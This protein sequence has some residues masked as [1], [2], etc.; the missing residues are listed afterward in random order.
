MPK[1]MDCSYFTQARTIL[2]ALMLGVLI[3][4]CGDSTSDSKP[5]DKNGVSDSGVVVSPND[6]RQY[7]TLTLDNGI[8]VLLVSDPAVEK[9]AAALSVGVGLL[10][11]PMAYQGMAHYLEHML[12]L[13]TEKYP[14]S[15]GYMAFIQENGGANNAY[16]WLDITNYMFEVKNSAYDSALDRFAHFFKSPLLDPEYIEKEKSAVNAEWSMRREMDYFSM[17]KLSRSL[18]GNHPANR[19][20]IGNLETLADEAD[21]TLHEATKDFYAQYYSANLMKVAM[22]SDRSLS[23]MAKLARD[24]FGDIS[25]KNIPLPKVTTAIDFDQ[26]AGKLIHYVP[27]EDQRM[28]Q[29][30]FIIDGNVDEFRVK[31]NEYL[32]YIIGS[33]MPHTPAATLKDLGWASS[34][35]ASSAPD[36]FGN[37]GVFSISVDLTE[38]GMAHRD[39]IVNLL[40]GYLDQLKVAGVD[41]RYAAEF[42]TSLDNQFKF[43]EKVNDFAYVSQLAGAMQDYP[44]KHAIDAPFRF[45]GFD[46]A[47]VD[48]VLN[49]LTP[50]RAQV[51]YVSKDEPGDQ[52]MH[53]YSGKYSIK[54]LSVLSPE[55][56]LALVE[57]YGLAM[58]ALNTL[59]PESFAVAHANATPTRVVQQPGLEIWLQGSGVYREQPKG[60]TQIYLNTGSR[61]AG[62]ENVVLQALWTDLYNLRQATLFTEASI[63]GMNASVSGSHGLKLNFSGFTDKQGDLIAKAL[64]A[65][66]FTPTADELSQAVD[67]FE[68]G[69]E[70]SKRSFPVRQLRPALNRLTMSGNYSEEALKQALNAVTV[71]SFNAYVT[72]ELTSAY[73]RAY[74]FGNYSNDTADSLAAVIEDALPGRRGERYIRPAMYAPEPGKS[75]VLQKD[76]PVEDLGMI[77]LFAAPAAT[78]ENI[79]RGEVLGA[80]LANRAFN[81]L[82]TEEQLGYA[83]GGLAT[84]VGE[85]PFLGFYIQTPVKEPV[86]MLERFEAFRHEYQANLAELTAEDFERI[87]A[88][89]LTN[90]TEPPKNLAEE[91]RPFIADW[92]KERYDFDSRAKLI[93]AVEAV[94]IEDIRRYYDA[95]VMAEEPSKVL[96]QLRG[97]AFADQPF[98][99]IEGATVVADVASFHKVMAKQP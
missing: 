61:E 39:T 88:G 60:F 87:K 33:E 18:M 3:I 73:A 17:Y 51:W 92:I 69:L 45:E 64:S 99:E 37:Y 12:F 57:D 90:L 1:T 84:L 22:V 82:R 4:G 38:A 2:G 55:R 59:L 77:Y 97:R 31:P 19:F 56:R 32:S 15:D 11:D 93:A 44:S 52:E 89:V 23:D 6:S 63:A 53:F 66:R 43:L 21:S 9:S 47:A 78:V 94:T 50:E 41:D 26:A 86:A 71:D 91:A 40:F 62:P 79:A 34:L 75:V 29:I 10:F 36:Q 14:E 83:A 65:L 58:P 54:P 5:T 49:Q 95:T 30:D 24:N 48:R 25:N 42:K 27:Q 74:L 13:G 98:A 68:R 46:K 7:Q 76:L 20:L 85:H 28:V 72:N 70:N 16:T 67:R 8:E 81:R 96:V 35:M 80:H